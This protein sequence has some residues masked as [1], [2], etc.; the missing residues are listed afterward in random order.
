VC[1]SR[2]VGLDVDPIGVTD[3]PGRLAGVVDRLFADARLASLYDTLHPAGERGDFG[4]YLPLVM[5][6]DSVLDV[7]CGTGALLHMAREAGHAGRLHGLDPGPGMLA[8]ARTRHDIEWTLGSLGSVAW[9]REFDLVVITGHAFQVFTRDEEIRDVLA[10]IHR[11]L[12]DTG[13]FV[14]E[15]RNPLVRA[16]ESWT[17]VNAVEVVDEA[18]RTLRM[19]HEVDTPVVGDIVSFTT[20]YSSSGWARP[21]VSRSTLR[22]LDTGAVSS[23][24]S[25]AGLA[26]ERQFGD[27]TSQ[28]LNDSSPEII[29]VARRA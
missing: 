5:E 15:T 6:A 19:E 17:P 20:A 24:L 22:F 16:W 18:G 25:D 23:F 1:A 29:T 12:T 4:F 2:H 10:A 9:E 3:G 11:A 13:R 14:F 7:G 27:W 21:E 8:Q 26:I 28:P